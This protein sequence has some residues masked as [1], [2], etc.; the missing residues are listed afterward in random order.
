MG[1][2]LS[3]K[4]KG[5]CLGA[6]KDGE[7]TE[8]TEVE[9]KETEN[10]DAQKDAEQNGEK[11]S[12][13]QSET[14]GGKEEE[15]CQAEKETG[16][17]VPSGETTKDDA[18]L[19]PNQE[20]I[21]SA[22]EEGKGEQ[23]ESSQGEPEI[24]KVCSNTTQE[25]VCEAAKEEGSAAEK[26]PSAQG[27]QK[28][29]DGSDN[30][31]SSCGPQ[32]VPV[33]E[34]EVTE[35]K[36]AA[37]IESEPIKETVVTNA[38][39]EPSQVSKPAAEQKDG[40][41]KE[42]MPSVIEQTQCVSD[43]SEEV[44][45]KETDNIQEAP[46]AAEPAPPAAEPAPPAAEPAPPAAEPAPPAAEPAPPAAD[47]RSEEAS[48]EA[49]KK[50]MDKAQGAPPAAEPAQEAP[51]AAHVRSEEPQESIT[52]LDEPEK[53][54]KP[55]E[56]LAK[57]EPENN[58]P[59]TEQSEKLPAQVSEPEP[60]QEGEPAAET[61]PADTELSNCESQDSDMVNIE[62]K[63]A[64]TDLR[65][66]SVVSAE[67][68]PD[69]NQVEQNIPIE[70]AA[71]PNLQAESA[72][73]EQDSGLTEEKKAEEDK[74]VS[75][76]GDLKREDDGK[77]EPDAKL[78]TEECDQIACESECLPPESPA[79]KVPD[80]NVHAVPEESQNQELPE[81][82]ELGKEKLSPAAQQTNDKHVSNGLPV[83]EEMK[84]NGSLENGSDHAISDLNGQSHEIACSE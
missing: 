26:A 47:V 66:P 41:S 15:V 46:P 68:I 42:E 19:E 53:L 8:T 84:V 80:P 64:E 82:E 50:E 24:A 54:P 5:Y 60:K 65:P 76:Q 28:A 57:P 27:E 1:A 73:T 59:V 33:Q 49:V 40:E 45:K 78:A 83:K 11:P 43:A 29:A 55:V 16:V 51:P 77:T 25:Q 6:G 2:K 4:K 71:V 67:A 75:Q 3:K 37:V 56:E 38:H 12:T 48:Q 32:G 17:D 18:K 69:N 34:P 31:K 9:Q 21:P 13:D 58:E 62:A 14:N 52:Q 30:L 72:P 7:S 39:A 63:V 79:A 20:T 10:Q 23:S 44:V 22:K 81:P 36:V 35:S 61:L 70:E 74:L